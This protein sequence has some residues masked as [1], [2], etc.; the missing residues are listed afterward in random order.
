MR[1]PVSYCSPFLR[2]FF[3]LRL[4]WQIVEQLSSSF[5]AFE[6]LE[7]GKYN[8]PC[9]K[10]S[11][12]SIAVPFPFFDNQQRKEKSTTTLWVTITSHHS[13]K[14]FVLLLCHGRELPR[15]NATHQG[16]PTQD[17]GLPTTP[18]KCMQKHTGTSILWGRCW[19]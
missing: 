7:T 14:K 3:R 19:Y 11:G 1:S 15:F 9:Q 17:C 8:V 2:S 10:L 5:F 6:D 18:D 13:P 12:D 4:T 16:I